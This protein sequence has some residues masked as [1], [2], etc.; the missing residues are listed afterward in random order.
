M[1][2]LNIA[3]LASDTSRTKA[4]LQVMLKND[5]KPTLCVVYAENLMDLKKQADEYDGT[6]EFGEFFNKEIPLLVIIDDYDIPYVTIENKDINSE[7]LMSAIKSLEQEYVIYSG[8]G[9]GILKAPLFQLGKKFIHVHAGM[10]PEYRGS[11][12]AYYSIIDNGNIGVTAFFLDEGLDDG[13]IICQHEY[14]LPNKDVDIDYVYEPYLRA[15]ELVLALKSYIDKRRFET[16]IQDESKAD[17]YFII[18]PVLKH[19]A[20][21]RVLKE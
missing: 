20:I 14:E 15:K 9:G 13:E 19:I 8:Y 11:T 18:H 7:S 4:Y 5:I 2:L 21:K 10:V 1:N 6:H 17:T 12:T 3:L 16:S